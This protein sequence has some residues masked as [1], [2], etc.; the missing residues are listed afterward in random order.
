MPRAHLKTPIRLI[1]LL[2]RLI[3]MTSER[4]ETVQ[5][6]GKRVHWW[7]MDELIDEGVSK[8]NSTTK[9]MTGKALREK[10]LHSV[11]EMKA[12]KAAGATKAAVSPISKA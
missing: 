12:G 10:L 7:S 1:S 8:M 6:P 5:G 4:V 2:I 11:R 3:L 9:A